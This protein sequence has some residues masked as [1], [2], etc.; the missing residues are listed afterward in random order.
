MKEILASLT[1]DEI[2]ITTLA[3]NAYGN[4]QHPAATSENLGFFTPFYCRKC[5]EL[6]VAKGGLSEKG[7]AVAQQAIRDFSIKVA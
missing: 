2:A 7:V 3:I 1:K 4:G 5:L 6:A